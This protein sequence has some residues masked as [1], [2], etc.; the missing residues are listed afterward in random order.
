MVDELEN[1]WLNVS[2]SPFLNRI[3]DISD[4][5]FYLD[6]VAVIVYS[7]LAKLATL[8]TNWPEI[9]ENVDRCWKKIPG[10]VAH[11]QGAVS[12]KQNPIASFSLL[13]ESLSGILSC[14]GEIHCED[15]DEPCIVPADQTVASLL[16]KASEH[17]RATSY[18]INHP[19]L[20]L[21]SIVGL[22]QLCFGQSNLTSGLSPNITPMLPEKLAGMDLDKVGDISKH[23]QVARFPLLVGLLLALKRK[24]IHQLERIIGFEDAILVRAHLYVA[25]EKEVYPKLADIMNEEGYVFPKWASSLLYGH[26]DWTSNV[27]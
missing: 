8:L 27:N 23:S 9:Q 11:Y 16:E 18:D 5:A 2:S 25:L 13:R 20:K 21:G 17:F 15:E 7:S 12:M 3:Y 14:M 26:Y 19:M 1:N 22:T 10:I 4:P 24:W 6:Q